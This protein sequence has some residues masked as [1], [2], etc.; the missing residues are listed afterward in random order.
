MPLARH[1]P[2]PERR[3]AHH[4]GV[5]RLELADHEGHEVGGHPDAVGE[6]DGLAPVAQRLFPDHRA[7]R[8]RGEMLGHHQRDAEDRLEGGLVP[9]RE[10]PPRVR[11]LELGGRDGVR[12]AG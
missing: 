9:A 8:D 2:D 4:D 5:R 12:L 10:G 6:G 3:A 7:I 11:G 1:A